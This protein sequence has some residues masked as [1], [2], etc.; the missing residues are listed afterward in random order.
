MPWIVQRRWYDPES[1]TGELFRD[2][3]HRC[4]TLEPPYKRRHADG[5]WPKPRA[6]PAGTYDLTVRH[7]ARFNRLMPHVEN[8][9]QFAG[10]LIHWGNFPKDTE[11]CTLVGVT[12][13]VD[14]VGHSGDEFDLLFHE[15][16][17]ACQSGPQTITYL[18]P[19][20]APAPKV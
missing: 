18:D 16:V 14:F 8:V 10:V 3:V 19:P 9:P 4:W 17:E 13:G 12:H 7:S 5:T 15:I 2:G 1:V 20:P 11:G 6:I